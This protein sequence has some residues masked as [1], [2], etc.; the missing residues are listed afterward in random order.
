MVHGSG[1]CLQTNCPLYG[2]VQEDCCTG[3]PEPTDEGEIPVAPSGPAPI[4]W[5]DRT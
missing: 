2:V 5:R 1:V 3:A 4:P